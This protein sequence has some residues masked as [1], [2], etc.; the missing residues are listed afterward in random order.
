MDKKLLWHSNYPGSNT[1]YGT[2]TGLFVPRI[3]ELGWDVVISCMTGLQGRPDMW[4][5]FR[6]L[7]A[8]ACRVFQ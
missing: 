8:G 3:A 6:C 5:G 1:G 7:P 2:Q 4:N